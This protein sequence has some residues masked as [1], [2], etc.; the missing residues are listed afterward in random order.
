MA[1]RLYR[2]RHD[3]IIGGVA[4]GIAENLDLDA[5]IV[6]IAW[7]VLALVAPIT[8]LF[9]FILMF[10]V[11]EEP[12]PAASLDHGGDVTPSRMTR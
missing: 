12:L 9:Y 6:R 2:S 10:V 3:R 5:T 7:V 11:P 4:G 1:D 8:P